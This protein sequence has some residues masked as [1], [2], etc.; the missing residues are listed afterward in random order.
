MAQIKPIS[1]VILNYNDAYTTMK[2]VTHIRDYDIFHAIV[3]VDN[4]STDDSFATLS[5]MQSEKVRVISSGFNGG[6]G[7][8]NNVGIRYIQKNFDDDCF[9]IANPDVVFSETAVQQLV[10][11]MRDHQDCGVVTG[12]QNGSK[13]T[14]VW[15]EV[16]I[17]GDQLF[18]NILLNAIFRPRYY[19]DD[20]LGQSVCNVY[21]VSGCF[22]LAN[23]KAFSEIGMYDEEF[24]L[25]EEEKCI[26]DKLKQFGWSSFLL[27]DVSF[28]HEH[29][30][31]ISKSLKKLGQAKAAVLKSNRLYLKKY[32]HVSACA[33]PLIYLYHGLCYLEQVFWD[34]V[35]PRL[36]S[37]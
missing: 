28:R 14:S 30:V 11:F 8:G 26:A 15:K 18:N 2:L 24:F 23:M 13:R 34:F 25:F 19:G 3:V 7:F 21:A 6:Y 36:I 1:C 16:G 5:Q 4:M 35:K 10:G 32:K 12:V 29:S 33:M 31:S 37:K 27:T 20:Y 22:L 9:V 17:I